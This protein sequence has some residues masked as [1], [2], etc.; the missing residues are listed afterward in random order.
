MGKT[1]R[2][3]LQTGCSNQATPLVCQG[4]E[5]TDGGRPVAT[6]GREWLGVTPMSHGFFPSFQGISGVI[7]KNPADC[8]L[9]TKSLGVPKGLG[10]D[11]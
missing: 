1:W 7:P 6:L 8:L 10:A 5:E 11:K 3:H 9:R 2:S 4:G